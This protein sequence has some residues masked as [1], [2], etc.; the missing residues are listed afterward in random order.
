MTQQTSPFLEGKYGWNYGESGWNTGMDENL[1][2]FSFM[3]DKNVDGIVSSLPPVVNGQAYFLTTD[4]RLYFAVGTTW[5]SSPTPKWFTI[6]LKSSGAAYQFDGTSM[7]ASPSLSGINTRVTAI[8]ATLATLGTAAYQNSTYFATQSALD[9]ASAQAATYS[10]SVGSTIRSDLANTTDYTKGVSQVG[11]AVR[12]LDSYAALRLYTGSALVVQVAGRANALDKAGGMFSRDVSDTTSADNDVITL[13]DSLGRRW[14]RQYSG[15]IDVRWGG[16]KCDATTDDTAAVQKVVNVCAS[17]PRWAPMAVTGRCLLLS[18]VMVDRLV[19]TTLSDWF[20]HGIGPGAGFYAT[21]TVKFFDSTI[22]T[23]IDPRSE[24]IKFVNMH[25][26]SSSIFNAAFVLSEKFL[27]VVSINCSYRLIRYISSTLYI[28]THYFIAPNI[29]NV[30]SSF[31]DCAGSYDTLI[32]DGIV[33]NNFTIIRCIDTARG[34]NGLRVINSVIEGGQAS[35]IIATGLNGFVWDNNHVESQVAEDLNLWGGVLRNTTVNI[36]RSYIFN[37]LGA[38]IYHGPTDQ[39]SSKGV[40]A[41]GLLHE[42]LAQVASWTSI[43][44]KASPVADIAGASS[45]GGIL[46][47]GILGLSTPTGVAQAGRIYQGSGAPSTGAGN[48]GDTYFR[49]DTP[50]VALQRIYQKTAVGVWTGIV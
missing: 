28:Q 26:E 23:T 13:V 18:S 5:Y 34:T 2:K 41:S 47:K 32:D 10:D 45:F 25:F 48:V 42:N 35:T 27:R 20:V 22:A 24:A 29:R 39:V 6:I 43:G 16:A 19:D 17:F 33:E 49:T 8:E 50:T 7:V 12:M 11:G 3:F 38:A 15:Y 46:T 14:K 44:D 4:K 21:G 1:L 40:Y 37:P 30:P 9:V 31:I 36:D